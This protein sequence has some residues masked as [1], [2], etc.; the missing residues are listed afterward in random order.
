MFLES[1]RAKRM[2][3]VKLVSAMFRSVLNCWDNEMFE[4]ICTLDV[5]ESGILFPQNLYSFVKIVYNILHTSG[6]YINRK[7]SKLFRN[8]IKISTSEVP[9][10]I[11]YTYI[12]II[13]K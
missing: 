4:N 2:E 11:I 1:H 6:S 8:T 12:L 5:E 9:M 7:Y 13:N 10:L 3:M